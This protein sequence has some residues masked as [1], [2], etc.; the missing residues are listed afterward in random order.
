MTTSVIPER[1][2]LRMARVKAAT[3]NGE[4]V[5]LIKVPG[6]PGVDIGR[7]VSGGAGWFENPHP[8]D[9][10]LVYITDEDNITGQGA[11]Q[12][13]GKYI[14]DDVADQNQKGWYINKHKGYIDIHEIQMFGIIPP[15]FYLKIVA[16][17]GDGS[18]DT[19]RGNIKW[20]K[21]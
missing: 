11:G 4:A 5:T 1:A 21:R 6:T 8:D 2:T 16:T 9:H 3:V 19:F 13:V 7:V 12:V 15:G 10:V 17:K 14:D 18:S 20:G